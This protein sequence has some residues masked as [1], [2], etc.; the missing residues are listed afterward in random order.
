MGEVDLVYAETQLWE[1][2][3]H[4]NGPEGLAMK[5]FYQHR[6]P[7]EIEKPGTVE[8]TSEDM[9]SGVIRFKSGAMAN[10]LST[11]AAP[12]AD[13]NNSIIYCDDG[14]INLGGSRSGRPSTITRIE[15]KESIPEDCLLDLVPGF[16][17]DGITKK[18]FD[19]LSRMASY[20]L[21]FATIDAKIIAIE[22]EDFA[23][24]IRTG[25]EPEVTG[26][27]GLDAVALTYAFLESGRK[28]APVYFSDVVADR[29]NEYQQ[30]INDAFGLN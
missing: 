15:E 2:I 30:E 8:C 6:E 27:V 5:P 28:H 9:A 10:F 17:L 19:G 4:V 3:R 13:I 18:A 26:Q 22:L 11:I 12:G 16:Q 24:A 21:D 1:K 7:L 23:D 20:N 29:T 25:G 14:S